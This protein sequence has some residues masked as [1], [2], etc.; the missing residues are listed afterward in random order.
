[1]LTAKSNYLLAVLDLL[2]DGQEL[3]IPICRADALEWGPDLARFRPGAG[4]A[5]SPPH[6][7]L[8]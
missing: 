6:S 7:G 5:G 8:I 3:E 1:M 4:A 2:G